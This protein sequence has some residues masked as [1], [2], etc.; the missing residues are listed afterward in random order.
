[1]GGWLRAS[2]AAAIVLF[3]HTEA[4]AE[5][6]DLERVCTPDDACAAWFRVLQGAADLFISEHSTRVECVFAAAEMIRQHGWRMRCR[7]AQRYDLYRMTRQTA[8][9]V[10]LSSHERQSECRAAAGPPPIPEAPTFVSCVP[11]GEVIEDVNTRA[12]SR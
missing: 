8:D 10:L 12:R 9:K 4:F 1:V 3:A 6:W 2:L 7:G 5:S 11:V